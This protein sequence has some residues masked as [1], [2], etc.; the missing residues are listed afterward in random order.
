MG[1]KRAVTAQIKVQVTG[2]QA[3]PAPP[4][5]TA[6]GPH[7]VNIGQFVQQFNERTRDMMGITIPCVITVYNDRTFEFVLKSP[8]AAVL[9]KKVA[10]VAKGSG[11]P[12]RMKVGSVTTAQLDQI[13]KQKYEDLNASSLDQARKLVGRF[14]WKNGTSVKTYEV[15]IQKGGWPWGAWIAGSS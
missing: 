3:T 14:G 12:L 5:G 1:K 10:G 4:V 11:S 7:G 6:L 8:P 9:L 15:T 13:A 2:G